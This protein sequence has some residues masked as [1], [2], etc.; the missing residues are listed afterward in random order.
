MALR[1][2]MVS[3]W[4]LNETSGTRNDSHGTNHLTD[5]NTVLYATG[6]QGNGADFEDANSEYLNIADGSQ[7]G[8]D[9]TGD[10]SFSLWVKPETTPTGGAGMAFFYKWAASQQQY[11]MIYVD[12][13]G[14]KKIRFIGYQTCGG[15]NINYDFTT[16]ALSTS[17]MTHV[18]L[19]FDAVGHASGDGTAELW[20]NGVSQGTVT[21]ASFTGGQNCTGTFSLSSLGSGIQ[22]YWDGIMDEVGV[23]SKWLSDAEISELYNSGA[24]LTYAGTAGTVSVTVSAGVNAGTFS[25]P[26]Y[27]AKTNFTQAITTLVATFSTPVYTVLSGA[28][29]FVATVVS[30]TFSIPTYVAKINVAIAQSTLSTTLSVITYAI[31]LG[32]RIMQATLSATFTTAVLS[33]VGAVWTKIARNST[34]SWTRS[35]RNND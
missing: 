5:N 33:K 27:T 34:G 7:S 1:D 2:S 11:G 22:W 13:A 25:I 20:I 6:V 15:S 30:A 35:D 26:T 31:G 18:V 29:L 8:L 19:R 24:G 9:L 3:W 4:E 17:A 21:S 12:V 16:G 14:T 32:S 10:R 28:V 23:W